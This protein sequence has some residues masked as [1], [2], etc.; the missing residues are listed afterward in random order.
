MQAIYQ[1]TILDNGLRIVTEKIPSVRSVS[2]GVWVKTGSRNESIENNGISHFLEHMVFKGTHKRKGVEIAQSLESVGGSINAFTSKEI[3]CY[4]AHI[5]DEHLPLAIDVLTDLI[6]NAVL[7]KDELEKEKLVVLEEISSLEDSPDELI[8]EYF[9][10]DLFPDDPL[11]YTILGK[12]EKVRN[13]TRESLDS[14]RKTNYNPANIVIAAAGNLSHD[15]LVKTVSDR[16]IMHRLEPVS[17]PKTKLNLNG[18]GKRVLHK[19]ITQ[20]HFCIGKRALPYRSEKKYSLLI[21]NTLLGGGMSSRLFQNIREKYGFA[22]S[23][24]SFT[25]FFLDTGVFGVYM[26]TDKA[27]I[28]ESANLVN[29]EFNK[30]L[31]NQISQEEV[32]RTKNQLKGNLMLSLESTSSRMTRLA[33]MEIYLGKYFSLDDVIASINSV[34][35]NEVLELAA[36]LMNEDHMQTTILMPS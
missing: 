28:D 1:K 23:I 11:G 13:F 16:V 25:D 6:F 8:H 5:L 12:A 2:L 14:F 17:L 19:S 29:Q 27:K 22:Y 30:I 21:L 36:G 3:T 20:A 7:D 35:R 31:D 9:Q 18:G 34:E 10:E 24:Y 15:D 4:F 26:G 33:K 32:D